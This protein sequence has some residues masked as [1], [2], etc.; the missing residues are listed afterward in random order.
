[1]GV[2]LFPQRFAAGLASFLGLVTVLLSALGVY[3]VISYNVGRQGREIGIRMALGAEAASVS[4][5]YLWQG[6]RLC[7]PG[8]VIGT[9]AAVA[10]GRLMSGLLLGLSPLD[11]FAFG[12]SLLLLTATVTLA[13]WVPAR[14]AAA[15]RPS[16]A[17]RSD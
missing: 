5:H 4:R 2:G 16:Q 8:L 7:L 10:V 1:M 6:L 9:V 13:A 14:R 12:V 3:G 11:P 17:L 15:L